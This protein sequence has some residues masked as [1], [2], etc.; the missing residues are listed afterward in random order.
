MMG[1]IQDATGSFPLGLL[2]IATGSITATPVCGS[3]NHWTCAIAAAVFLFS[4][5]AL[6]L[7]TSGLAGSREFLAAYCVWMDRHF[8]LAFEH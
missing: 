3:N 4:V 8:G 6:V 5:V 2:A 7:V 1:L